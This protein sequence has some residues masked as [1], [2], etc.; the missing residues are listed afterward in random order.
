EGQ[1]LI[2]DKITYRFYGPSRGDIVI[3]HGPESDR[4]LV[5]R[6]IG[7]PGDVIDMRDGK[8][9]LNGRE[10][11]EPY[12][13]GKTYPNGMK[14]PYTVPAHKV[15][16]MGDNREVSLDSRSPEIGPIDLNSIEGKIIFRI[17]P[18]SK[19]GTID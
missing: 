6:I 7:L 12:V 13:K 11:Y 9:Y 8:L 18:L 3:V 19:F 17:W 16:V 10:L 2:E 1:R 4:R 15:F 14:L 5:K